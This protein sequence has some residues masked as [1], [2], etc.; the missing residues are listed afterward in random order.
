MDIPGRLGVDA[1]LVTSGTN[2]RY[3]TGFTAED[4]APDESSGVVVATDST[5]TV[6]T[7]PTNLPWAVTEV[8][9]GVEV[10]PATR[11]W[12]TGVAA[13]VRAR[14]YHR[15]GFEE[16]A[17]TVR[18][19]AALSREL[20]SATELV[21]IGDAVDRL[22]A[23]KRADELAS[24]ESA[25]RTTDIAFERASSQIEVSM[26]ERDIADLVRA[27]LR[28]AGSDGEAFPTIVASGPNAAKPH[29]VPGD[30]SIGEGEPVIIDMGAKVEGYRGDLTRTIWLGQPSDQ[31]VTMYRLVVAAQAAAIGTVRP[32]VPAREVDTAARAVCIAAGMGDH[33][34]HSVGHGIG[35]RIH[36]EPSVNQVSGETLQAGHVITIEPGL[37]VEGWGGI[38]IED[39]LL[40]DDSGYRNLTGAPKRM[41]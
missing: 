32:G 11:P 30:R 3:L 38:R 10:L 19:H 31:L 16:A 9:D 25:M 6:M 8:R 15:L 24:I 36:E 33:V 12:T 5:L 21:P 7:S 27:E 2:R 23:I 28:R 20:G 17:M 34:I 29:H 18:D 13:E 26:T 39:V 1:I 4:H 37:Y 40:V 22:R 41:P 35:L 14:G